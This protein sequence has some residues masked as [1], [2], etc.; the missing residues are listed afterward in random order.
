VS[1]PTFLR[2]NQQTDFS[3]TIIIHKHTQQHKHADN[4]IKQ[5]QQQQQQQHKIN[6]KTTTRQDKQ[7]PPPWPTTIS[8]ECI[9]V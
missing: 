6:K 8:I 3:L 9:Q 2:E 4:N 7:T 5:Q 1:T